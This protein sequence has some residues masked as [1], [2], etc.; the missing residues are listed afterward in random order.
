MQAKPILDCESESKIP[1]LFHGNCL[2]VERL[3]SAQDHGIFL[4]LKDFGGAR[5]LQKYFPIGSANVERLPN[6]TLLRVAFSSGACRSLYRAA[7]ARAVIPRGTKT[8]RGISA[9]QGLWVSI[10]LVHDSTTDSGAVM[11][12]VNDLYRK[13]LEKPVSR[14]THL[15][16]KWFLDSH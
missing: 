14:E 12:R 4:G 2:F 11:K 6:S 9:V 7:R 10:S 3:W 16:K 8:R 13:R 5:Y 15:E 1:P